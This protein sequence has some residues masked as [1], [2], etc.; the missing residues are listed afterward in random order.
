MIFRIRKLYQ[1]LPE[2][3]ILTHEKD[4]I[5]AFRDL[6]RP[7]DKAKG[8]HVHHE[9]EPFHE[10][11]QNFLQDYDLDPENIE[12]IEPFHG[13][14]AI[15]DHIIRQNFIEYHDERAVLIEMTAEEHL[16]IHCPNCGLKSD[17]DKTKDVE[18]L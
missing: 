5:G 14:K 10:I 17:S 2:R 11:Y 9:G 18:L 6:V 7:R 16:L 8:N 15:K 12:L 13:I 3:N 1:I 4:V